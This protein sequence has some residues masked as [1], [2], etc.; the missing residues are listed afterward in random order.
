M[1]DIN[2]AFMRSMPRLSEALLYLFSFRSVYCIEYA[3]I[4]I[5]LF[6]SLS[7]QG[8]RVVTLHTY[9]TAITAITFY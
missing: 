8:V 5:K 3:L 6:W 2:N 7:F 1:E 4:C 9:K